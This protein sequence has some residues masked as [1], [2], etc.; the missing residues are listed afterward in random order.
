MIEFINAVSPFVYL[1]LIVGSV[2]FGISIAVNFWLS[3]AIKK[4]RKDTDKNFSNNLTGLECERV[5]FAINTA[6]I[7]YTAWLL[8]NSKNKKIIRRNKYRK[9][10]KLK[11]KLPL[12]QVDVKDIFVIL[13]KDVYEALQLDSTLNNGYLSFS[14]NQIFSTLNSV[15]SRIDEI[16]S[17][18]GVKW[19]KNIK[20][21][22]IVS[23]VEFYS[24][25]KSF[26]GKFWV[27]LVYN[28]INF[29]TWFLRI[30]S[31]VSISKYF[32]KNLASQNLSE[33]IS[34][35]LV[36]IVGKEVAVIYK[37]KSLK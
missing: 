12:K 28:F 2:F 25:Y 19:L 35:T 33:I 7:S 37:N 26:L 30:F 22:I 20:I 11:G 10:F 16:L 34:D 29:F 24:N 23:G 21:A 3:N 32:I 27:I 17:N 14:K 1:F 15:T 6:K 4:V 9:A 8:Q 36:E 18:S 31:P 5:N 13:L